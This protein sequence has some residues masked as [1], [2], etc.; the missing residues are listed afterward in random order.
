MKSHEFAVLLR[1]F[2]TALATS[3]A[4]LANARIAALAEI[5]DNVPDSTVAALAKRIDAISADFEP[6]GGV[7]ASDVLPFLAALKKLFEGRVKAAILTDINAVEA[8]LRKRSS[9]GLDALTSVLTGPP[10]KAASKTRGAKPAKKSNDATLRDDLVAEFRQNLEN[11]LGDPDRFAEVFNQLRSNSAVGKREIAALAKQMT[12][13]AGR[14][15]DDGLKK[16]LN[17]H[18]TLMT[19]KAKSV[20]TGGR[21]AA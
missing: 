9:V 14:S 17:R 10:M 8:A 12:G 6:S 11:S 21:S 20:A 16:I 13:S 1:D 4:R 18:Q 7:A 19:F 5:F 15:I 2:G 3:D